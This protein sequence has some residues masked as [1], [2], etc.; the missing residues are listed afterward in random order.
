[1]ARDNL[2][3][4]PLSRV[5]L[6]LSERKDLLAERAAY[7]DTLLDS[8]NDHPLYHKARCFLEQTVVADH[9]MEELERALAAQKVWGH[10]DPDFRAMVDGCRQLIK[11]R[12]T[13]LKYYQKQAEIARR[14]IEDMIAFLD[15][16]DE[17]TDQKRQELQKRLK[18]VA[19]SLDRVR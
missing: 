9:P 1:M 19:R 10:L 3:A 7:I 18:Q 17:M 16:P 6:S 4:P 2:P 8:Q 11:E 12:I 13:G 14:G 5:E 15:R